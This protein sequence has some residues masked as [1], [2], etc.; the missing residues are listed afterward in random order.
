MN[1]ERKKISEQFSP[2]SRGIYDSLPNSAEDKFGD[3]QEET[4]ELVDDMSLDLIDPSPQMAVQLS[5]AEPPIDDPEF[6]PVSVEDLANA[7]NAIARAVPADQVEWY[8][9]NLHQLLD[10]AND[11]SLSDPMKEESEEKG[12]EEGVRRI[13]KKNILEVLSPEDESEMDEYRTGGIDYLGSDVAE[14]EEPPSTVGDEVN[15]EDMAKEFDYSG[16]SG[17]RQEINRIIKKMEYF[18]QNVKGEDLD[19]LMDY[20]ASQ[21]IDT[22]E[23]VDALPAE[24]IE[25]LRTQS[26]VVKS[27]DTFRFF[28]VSAFVVPAYKEVSRQANRRLDDAVKSLHLPPSI[29]LTITNQITGKAKKSPAVVR[30]KLEKLAAAGDIESAEIGELA[31]KIQ[32]ALPA[33]AS[34]AEVG[35]DLIEKS[36]E[37]WQKTSPAKRKKLLFKAMEETEDNQ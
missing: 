37:R 19:A 9:K 17:M 2:T 25:L 4:E 20:A 30:R 12:V 5:V 7:A 33:L 16:P 28:F 32:A 27:L 22:L 11:R 31:A 34:A 3:E 21:Y 35:D 29:N 13:I 18:T 10:K 8:Y 26:Q 15:L 24:D 6:I 23:D 36:L 1:T 14:E